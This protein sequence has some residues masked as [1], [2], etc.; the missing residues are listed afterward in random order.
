MTDQPPLVQQSGAPAE[1]MPLAS[2]LDRIQQID[3]MFYEAKGWGSWMVMCANDR[4]ELV[5][6]VNA[7]YGLSIPHQFQA[8]TADGRRTD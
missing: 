4:E 2:M 1:R 8:R 3:R 6:R 5:D 7:A